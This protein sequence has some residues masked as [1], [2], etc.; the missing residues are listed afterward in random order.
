MAEY[1]RTSIRI[2]TKLHKAGVARAS[3]EHRDFSGHVAYLLE[4]D[5]AGVT[6]LDHAAHVAAV[7]LAADEHARRRSKGKRPQPAP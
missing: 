4:R 2:P 3:A 5:I 1:T 7:E 6:Q